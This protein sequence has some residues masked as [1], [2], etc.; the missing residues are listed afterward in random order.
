MGSGIIHEGLLQRVKAANAKMTIR[1]HPSLMLRMSDDL[2]Q[3]II[4][5]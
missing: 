4:K 2:L 1:L 5:C 3:L